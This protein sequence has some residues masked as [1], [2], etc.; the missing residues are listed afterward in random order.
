MQLSLGWWVESE[1]VS[2]CF[3][4]GV[5]NNDNMFLFEH[6]NS[7]FGEFNGLVVFKW[8]LM[9]LMVSHGVDSAFWQFFSQP[10]TFLRD[11]SLPPYG[12][13]SLKGVYSFG[14]SLVY[15]YLG[16]G[17]EPCSSFE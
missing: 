7:F 17:L 4:F 8:F 10:G 14:C 15:K 13:N 5:L 3:F 11:E 12:R 16:F 6:N 1:G 9:L 2:Q